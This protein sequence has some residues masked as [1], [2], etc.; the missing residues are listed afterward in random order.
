MVAIG[1]KVRNPAFTLVLGGACPARITEPN[2]IPMRSVVLGLRYK[3][4]IP[5][6]SSSIIV[7]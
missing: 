3:K 5:A 7:T 6:T 4:T 2:E 1:S